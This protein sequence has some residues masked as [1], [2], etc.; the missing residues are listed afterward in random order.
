MQIGVSRHRF[1]SEE[2]KGYRVSK[3]INNHQ[4]APSKM[5]CFIKYTTAIIH[6][7]NKLI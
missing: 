2:R 7:F 5:K 6:A 3:E 1:N 4:K